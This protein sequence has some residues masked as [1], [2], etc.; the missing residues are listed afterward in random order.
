MNDHTTRGR[1]LP[2]LLLFFAAGLVTLP[3]LSPAAERDQAR[4]LHDRIAGVPPSEEVL[5]AM[6]TAIR[7]GDPLDAAWQAM[8]NSAFYGVT[9]KNF[10]TPW[11]NEEQT[12]FAPLNDYTA[13]AIGIIRDEIP[14]TEILSADI[15]YVGDS[16]LG[17]PAYSPGS[18]AHYEEMERRGVD[19]KS[20]LV[21]TT[22]SSV[23]GIPA[24]ATAGVMTTRQAGRAFYIDG[25]NRAV[26][27]FTFLNH[28][29]R[30]IE[31]VKDVSRP[32]D[33][34]RQ[35]VSRSPGG[36]SRIYIN[37]CMGCHAGLDPLVQALAYYDY[38]YD[39]DPD[40]GRLVY[41]AEGTVDP[42]TGTRVQGK[43]LINA[44]N[45]EFGYITE[46]DSWVNYWRA[47]PNSVL[48]WDVNGLGLPDR[49]A[50]AKSMGR[51]LANTAVFAECQVKKV[52]QAVCLRPPV[53]AA[54]RAEI[55]RVTGLFRGNGYN[56]KQVF[57][58]TA[59]YCMGD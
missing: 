25:T 35:D 28:L 52:F 20:G 11:T 18:N 2:P 53:D 57:A 46:D 5:D 15:L 55:E 40:S 19:L 8:E 38:E 51:E 23:L 1:V 6:E 36:D 13:T 39:G 30:D 21:R 10:V 14:F 3:A 12:V 4:R 50:G 31:Q 22:Q 43:Y 33:R 41:N 7:N 42:E 34:I 9:L 48:G 45:F 32:T 24:E 29:C 54:D 49:G 27:R 56:L 37:N 17:L 59:V 58:E 47:G 16:G 44:G 26:V